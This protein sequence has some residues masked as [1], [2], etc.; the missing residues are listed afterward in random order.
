MLGRT[1]ARAV[2]TGA[3]LSQGGTPDSGSVSDV[4]YAL[5]LLQGGLG[6]LASFGMAALTRSPVHLLTPLIKLALL[7]VFAAKAARGRRWAVIA[8]IAI[9]AAALAGYGLG[10]ALG[11]LLPQLTWTASLVGLLTNVMLPAAIIWLCTHLLTATRRP[12]PGSPYIPPD[13]P[14]A[15]PWTRSDR[16]RTYTGP[17][18][19]PFGPP[20]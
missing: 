14:P 4:I 18:V 9:Q 3:D 16:T 19:G 13:P 12:R 6:I 20:R 15:N 2:A 17:F 7:V 8:L 11:L 10:A 1:A 5:V